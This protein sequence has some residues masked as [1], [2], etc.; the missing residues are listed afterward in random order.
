MA[1]KH[2]QVD[3][4]RG[5][6]I[7]ATNELAEHRKQLSAAQN[8]LTEYEEVQQRVANLERATKDEEVFNWYSGTNSITEA[9]L[10]GEYNGADPIVPSEG[11]PDAVIQLR[12]IRQWQ[13]ISTV[14]MQQRLQAME[15]MSAEKAVQYR[16]VI[17]ACTKVPADQLDE[18]RENVICVGAIPR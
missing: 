10:G 6:V 5:D 15:G 4:I 16:K 7:S 2:A 1:L 3:Q 12:R 18:V 11:S 13:S 8:R 17:A 14:V 9:T